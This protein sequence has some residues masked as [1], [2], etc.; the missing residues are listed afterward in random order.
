[1]FNI[2]KNKSKN[3]I[4]INEID[5]ILD[6]IELIDI[7]EPYEYQNGS[8]KKAKNIPMSNLLEKPDK[9]LNK[10][11]QY[12]ILC[13][14]GMRSARTTQFLQKQGFDVVNVSGGIGSYRG[15]NRK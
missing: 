7:R 8:I 15:M 2:F 10:K 3:S 6:N 5:E 12:Y 4:N 14:S 1:M 13:Q 11:N 9:Y